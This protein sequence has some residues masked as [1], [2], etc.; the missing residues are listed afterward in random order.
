MVSLYDDL[1]HLFR[2]LFEQIL[3]WGFVGMCVVVF[4]LFV[5]LVITALSST[6]CT[7]VDCGRDG[8]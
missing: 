3:V 4:A 1:H 8:E 7:G 5:L 2:V 6:R